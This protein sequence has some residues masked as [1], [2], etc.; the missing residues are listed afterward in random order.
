MGIPS[1]N[2]CVWKL[3][4]L[5]IVLLTI[6]RADIISHI[7]LLRH[8][9]VPNT[10]NSTSTICQGAI[11]SF[12]RKWQS[13]SNVSESVLWLIRI[14]IRQTQRS[15][16]AIPS[17]FAGGNVCKPGMYQWHLLVNEGHF[18]FLAA[19]SLGRHTILPVAGSTYKN[20]LVALL[21]R[22]GDCSLSHI[23]SFPQIRK[24]GVPRQQFH[25]PTKHARPQSSYTQHCS[26]LAWM[27][28][29]TWIRCS[30]LQR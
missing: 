15:F 16:R 29:S 20:I 26:V 12:C 28:C 11:P 23:P 10:A 27:C 1:I 17:R 8:P 7:M 19:L 9:S 13:S 2:W 24:Q 18:Q 30:A 5:I 6:C 22:S 21:R 3:R 4:S 14:N 25:F